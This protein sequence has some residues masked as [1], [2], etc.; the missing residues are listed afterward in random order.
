MK[1]LKCTGSYQLKRAEIISVEVEN[2]LWDKNPLGDASL[3]QLISTMIF[4]VG[5]FFSLCYGTEH[6]CLRF[7]PPQIELFEPQHTYM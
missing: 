7:K 4:Y 3:E 6:R 2:M 5:M 1:E